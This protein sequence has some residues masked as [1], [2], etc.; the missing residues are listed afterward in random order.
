MEAEELS[1]ARLVG[2]PIAGDVVLRYDEERG[3]FYVFPYGFNKYGI[4]EVVGWGW[5][6]D[7]WRLP[8]RAETIQ[9]LAEEYGDNLVINDTAVEKVTQLL[10]Y[11][12]CD[13]T[14][15][16]P[17]LS[18]FLSWLSSDR[19]DESEDDDLTLLDEDSEEDEDESI[20]EDEREQQGEVTR[21]VTDIGESLNH[22]AITLN[23]TL[24]FIFS[25]LDA[26]QA[27]LDAI[28]LR[29]SERGDSATSHSELSQGD[30]TA[31]LCVRLVSFDSLSGPT[32]LI[33]KEMWRIRDL[34]IGHAIQDWT[35]LVNSC[36]RALELEAIS[37][38]YNRVIYTAQSAFSR[39]E[40]SDTQLERHLGLRGRP[41]KVFGDLRYLLRT[42][43]GQH[44]NIGTQ[45]QEKVAAIFERG[46]PGK[47]EELIALYEE[48]EQYWVDYRNSSA[49][50]GLLAEAQARFAI[51]AVLGTSDR[52]GLLDLIVV[53]A[54]DVS[55]P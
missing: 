2:E 22:H 15:G 42:L 17:Q 29:D 46:F 1:L 11:D 26:I 37:K 24:N 32:Q 6:V 18:G 3:N 35:P 53:L 9:V 8:P 38:I 50:D 27:K 14:R 54:Q 51:D 34:F 4:R 43:S 19:D 47:S 13:R 23:E 41:R 44:M 5:V 33:L 16:R 45:D 52:P 39:T 12:P 48:S 40:F 7:R 31:E 49:H 55:T 30:V 20:E 28:Q 36:N 25:Q 10:G 21:I